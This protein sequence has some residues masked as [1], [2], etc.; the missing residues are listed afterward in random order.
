MSTIL[1]S[2]SIPIYYKQAMEHECWQ[3]AMEAELQALKE[4]HTWDI[5]SY[6]PNVKSIGSKWVY[7]VKL[8]SDGS[9]DRYKA[10]LVALG[11]K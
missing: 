10:Q 6:P 4:N 8:K 9:S 5:V 11:N 1:S 2:L 3:Q 7:T